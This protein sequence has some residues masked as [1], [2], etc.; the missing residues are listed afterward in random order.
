M[1]NSNAIVSAK[2]TVNVNVTVNFVAKTGE[3]VFKSVE[4]RIGVNPIISTTKLR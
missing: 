2:A 3:T 1:L 4:I